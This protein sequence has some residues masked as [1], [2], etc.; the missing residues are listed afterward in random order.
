MIHVRQFHKNGNPNWDI[1]VPTIVIIVAAIVLLSIV[2]GEN[3]AGLI[4]SLWRN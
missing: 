2:F 1:R 3:G 4:A